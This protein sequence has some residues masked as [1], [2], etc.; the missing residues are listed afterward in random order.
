MSSARKPW[1]KFYPSDWTSHTSLRFVSYAARGLWIELIAIAHMSDEYG[2]VLINGKAPTLRQLSVLCGGTEKET[3]CLIAELEAA[4][5]FDR[6]V[7]GE[8]VSRRM[9]RD[10]AK[11]E[12]DKANGKVGGN[13]RLKGGGARQPKPEDNPG[14][15]QGVNP[16]VIPKVDV[17]DKA[18]WPLASGLSVEGVSSLEVVVG[19]CGALVPGEEFPFDPETGEV[20]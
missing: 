18:Q 10:S 15:P 12:V 3:A 17:G 2:H 4:G 20:F 16:P 8:I 7:M 6:G 9:V 11:A 1:M 5:V 13:P 14:M 19:E